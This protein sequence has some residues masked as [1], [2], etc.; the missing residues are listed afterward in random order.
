MK[1]VRN[2]ANIL[3]FPNKPILYYYLY[4]LVNASCSVFDGPL[5]GFWKFALQ[6]LIIIF[7]EKL[8]SP[9]L[10]IMELYVPLIRRLCA[11]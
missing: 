3:I 8:A 4:P 10:G 9:P 7:Y 6:G 5:S 2:Q 1:L 11:K